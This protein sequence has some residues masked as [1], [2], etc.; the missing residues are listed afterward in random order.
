MEAAQHQGPNH[1][2]DA[3]HSITQIALANIDAA[4]SGQGWV[5]SSQG[6]ARVASALEKLFEAS[7]LRSAVLTLVSL[8]KHF[9]D[10]GHVA[11]AEGLLNVAA[12]ATSA[13][14]AQGEESAQLSDELTAMT[15]AVFASFQAE[16]VLKAAPVVRSAKY[17]RTAAPGT[18][19]V[20]SLNSLGRRRA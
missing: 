20:G 15:T 2:E 3:P 12:T 17:G 16:E 18:I 4:P 7:E 1:P 6:Q 9:E 5:F 19:S 13:L 11:V 14:D 10:R 8:A